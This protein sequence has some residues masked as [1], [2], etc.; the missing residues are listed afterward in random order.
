MKRK[1]IVALVLS[2]ILMLSL[3]SSIF[4][5]EKVTLRIIVTPNIPTKDVNTIKYLQD[6]A[7]AANVNIEWE[8]IT[9]GY[10]ELKSVMLASGDLPDILLGAGS[11]AESDFA[12]FPELFADL[13]KLL[14]FAPN[15]KKMFEEK[16]EIQKMVTGLDGA[17]YGLSK[18]QR[19]WPSN[20]TRQMINKE[21]LDRLNLQV[22]T[23]WEELYDVLLAFKEQDANGNGDVNDEVPMDWAPGISGFHVTSLIA[24]AGLPVSM[25]Q[26]AGYYV[27]DGVVKNFF[28]TEEYK[29]LIIF[30][31]KCF[32]AGLINPNVFTQDYTS[33]QNLSRTGVVGFTFGWDILDRMGPEVE[34]QYITI[35]PMKPTA[36]YTGPVYWEN[37]YYLMNYAY[38]MV[39]ISAD[40]KHKEEAMRFVDLFYDPY[41]GMQTLFGSIGECIQDNGDGTY[42]VLPP[43]DPT[44][45]PGTWKWIN[46]LADNSPMYISDSLQLTLPADMQKIAELDI[47][48]QE[49]LSLYDE[50]DLWPGP[51]LKY[52]PEQSTELSNYNLDIISI[53]SNKMATWVTVGGVE[54]EWDE[55]LSNLNSAGLPDAIAIFQEVYNQFL[56]K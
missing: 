4:A 15:V 5:E 30:L 31:N 10:G 56:G 50:D 25:Y 29:Q 46:A 16:P 26:G 2:I 49:G 28:V 47:V 54:R 27:H 13:T 14:E 53:L 38:P 8:P 3:T 51:F 6:M 39:A 18:Y 36:D 17:I 41:F 23:T 48:Y 42:T 55:Y 12:Q 20:M 34:S 37:D 22:P 32:E 9:S 1:S 11:V 40:S 52:T 35:P 33:M 21:W 44:I 43:A 24:G 45:D 19:Y 7:D